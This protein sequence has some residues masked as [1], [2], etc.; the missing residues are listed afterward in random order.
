MFE[1]IKRLYG[2]THNAA[3]VNSAVA[4]GWISEAQA[5]EILGEVKS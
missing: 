5:G 4:K 2:K 1:T 3:V